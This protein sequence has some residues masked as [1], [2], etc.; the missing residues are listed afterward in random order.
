MNHIALSLLFVL[1]LFS[2]DITNAQ[3]LLF[4]SPNGSDNNSG[5]IDSPFR[6]IDRANRTVRQLSAGIN[7]DIIVYLRGGIYEL[8]QPVIIDNSLEIQGGHKLIYSAYKDEAPIISG[9]REI[10]GWQ[11]HQGNIIKTVVGDADFRQLYANG[12]KVIKSREPNVCDYYKIN[13]WER[14]KYPLALRV[15]ASHTQL[16]ES[17]K[18]VEVVIQKN[19][20]INILRLEQIFREGEQAY[21]IPRKIERERSLNRLFP[22]KKAGQFYHLAN[23]YEFLDS[24]Y[25]WFYEKSTG[26]LFY[27]MAEDESLPD[28]NPIRTLTD[29]G[30]ELNFT[31]PR[32]DQLFIVKGENNNSIENIVIDGLT[33]R[34]TNWTLPNQEGYVGFQGDVFVS[35]TYAQINPCALLIQDARNI[36]VLNSKF[37]DLGANGI[38]LHSNVKD[39]EISGNVI[40]DIAGSGIVIDK[41]LYAGQNSPTA[42]CKN[43]H[44]HNNLISRVGTEYLGSVGIFA[45]FT[46][47]LLIE[48]NELNNLPYTGI[49]VGWGWSTKETNLRN[50]IIK[51]NY[52]HNVVNH[53]DDGGAIYTLSKQPNSV[54]E[55]NLIR[56]VRR[57]RWSLD[58]PT[59]GIYLDQGS[60][61]ISVQNNL[62]QNVALTI[63]QNP[64]RVGENN[65]IASNHNYN[66][67]VTNA[68]LKL[69]YL[70]LLNELSDYE[71]FC[72]SEDF[73]AQNDNFFKIDI[74][75]NPAEN[76]VNV[77]YQNS[78]I[79]DSEIIILD[80]MGKKIQSF[81]VENEE[82]LVVLKRID[83]TGLE[84]G[85]YLIVIKTADSQET[86]KI[87]VQP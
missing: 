72:S 35:D 79:Q 23:A 3:T 55:G 74:F 76:Y 32:I 33:F 46:D 83:L 15:P 44:I 8:D 28:S 21:L 87:I 13:N 53:L 10:I 11:P 60:D 42:L 61:E 51:N 84:A 47:S 56:N 25:E 54:I 4:V 69:R 81:S 29:D 30:Q 64:G 27:Y 65:R 20:T 17:S 2:C 62:F 75:P 6:T 31:I 68:G 1:I 73:A 26:E 38:I 67:N 37:T 58:Y 66:G 18:D 45:G 86:R 39:S 57:S 49:S 48:H 59:I 50:N 19:W 71:G 9:G 40:K 5:S 22:R 63:Y 12:R 82:N 24:P 14:T 7:E 16:L 85:I 70:H 43:I 36:Q 80:S 34:Y 77:L 41:L 52:L 78:Q